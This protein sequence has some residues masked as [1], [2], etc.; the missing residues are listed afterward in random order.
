MS[1]HRWSSEDAK[2]YEEGGRGERV[3]QWRGIRSGCRDFGVAKER[4]S[5][6]P[7]LL[8][9]EEYVVQA[10]ADAGYEVPA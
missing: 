9:E 8:H 1:S 10:V 5:V 4:V 3:R 7:A 2:W 6:T